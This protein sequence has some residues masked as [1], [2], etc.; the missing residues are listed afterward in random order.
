MKQYYE[1]ARKVVYA[2][3]FDPK[4]NEFPKNVSKDAEGYHVEGYGVRQPLI[5]GQWL[6]RQSEDDHV[7]RVLDPQEFEEL[8]EPALPDEAAETDRETI[9]MIETVIGASLSN[10]TIAW[11]VGFAE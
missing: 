7:Y 10:P 5:K 4:V 6:V 3:Q 9:R 2:E 11:L 1:R 8:Y